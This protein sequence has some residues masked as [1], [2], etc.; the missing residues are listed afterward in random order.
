MKTQADGSVVKTELFAAKSIQ[1][2][3]LGNSDQTRDHKKKGRDTRGTSYLLST[4]K[5]RPPA[6]QT[7][8]SD[9]DQNPVY[10]KGYN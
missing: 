3:R 5:Q 4:V 6:T 8:I 2:D 9:E 7:E 1:F 10:W